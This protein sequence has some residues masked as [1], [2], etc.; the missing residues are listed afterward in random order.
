MDLPSS[1]P[2]SSVLT[3]ALGALAGSY[4]SKVGLPGASATRDD[5]DDPA[6]GFDLDAAQER[7]RRRVD[8]LQARR[9]Q[10]DAERAVPGEQNEPCCASCGN[11]LSGDPLHCNT[12][13][14][15]QM[16]RIVAPTPSTH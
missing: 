7:L 5:D 2:M 16:G 13:G 11:R 1:D 15:P 14:C 8:D 4:F 9:V 12:D 6:S 3:S 10:R